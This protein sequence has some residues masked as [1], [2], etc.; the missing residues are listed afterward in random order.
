MQ[1]LEEKKCV[2]TVFISKWIYSSILV[3]VNY[4]N[5]LATELFCP[6]KENFIRSVNIYIYRNRMSAVNFFL[7]YLSN[8]GLN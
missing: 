8:Y 5:T 1:I 6:Y 7:F 2:N 4:F 3:A